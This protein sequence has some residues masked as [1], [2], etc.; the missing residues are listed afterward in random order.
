MMIVTGKAEEVKVHGI[1]RRREYTGEVC[2]LD[3]SFDLLQVVHA[4]SCLI[5]ITGQVIDL[6]RQAVV[7]QH[8]DLTE[9]TRGRM[10]WPEH[11]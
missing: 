9:I 7:L 4:L 2:L 5:H 6:F 3:S 8:A 11:S 1:T 10:P